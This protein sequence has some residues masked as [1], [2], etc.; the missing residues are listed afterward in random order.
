MAELQAALASPSA[1]VQ[2]VKQ[3]LDSFQQKLFAIGDWIYKRAN[4][5]T[6]DLVNTPDEATTEVAPPGSTPPA[7]DFDF[8][9][10]STLPADYETI[11]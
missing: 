3:G 11:E 5:E 2:Q 1:T 7:F 6:E 8:N 9:E 4:R 10:D